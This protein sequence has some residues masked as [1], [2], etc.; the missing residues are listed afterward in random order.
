MKKNF[1]DLNTKKDLAEFLDITI[2]QL[3]YNAYN[4]VKKYNKFHVPKKNG[5]KREI[6]APIPSLKT[7]QKKLSKELSK[8]YIPKKHVHSYTEKKGI[9]TNA[10]IHINQRFVFNIDLENFFPA[11]NFGRVS[12]VF[13][14]P[15]F[16]FND[17]VA[18]LL[19]QLCCH[20]NSLPQGSP[21]S[22]I[23]SN[24]ICRSLD[25]DLKSLAKN[26]KC[27]YS[28]YADDITFSTNLRKF[29]KSLCKIINDEIQIGE[30]LVEIIYKNGFNINPNKSSLR[31]PYEHQYVTGLTV[32]KKVNV[33][34][35]FLKQV[36]A[37][38]HA[39]EIYGLSKAAQEHFDKY[40]VRHKNKKDDSLFIKII[41]GKLL[42][43]ADIRGKNDPVF[44]KLLAKFK[45]LAP[46]DPLKNYLSYQGD[47]ILVYSEGNTD[48]MHLKHALE[49]FNV[50]DNY[51][52][53]NSAIKIYEY[54]ESLTIGDKKLME[55]LRGYLLSDNTRPII[56]V[57]DSDNPQTLGEF[58]PTRNRKYLNFDNR[59]FTFY[60]PQPFHRKTDK[61][62]IEHYY[63]NHDL[64]IKDEYGRRIFL[65][66][67]FND[68]SGEHVEMEN[69]RCDFGQKKLRMN[70]GIIDSKVYDLEERSLALSKKDFARN[71]LSKHDNFKKVNIDSFRLIFDRIQEIIKD[72]ESINN[73]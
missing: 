22:P 42:F 54:D 72:I 17:E 47:K 31:R 20:E 60:L 4:E 49:S 70:D 41:K 24:L 37:M 56:G 26:N 29:P 69:V 5:R 57:F 39:W 34:R 10:K 15:P 43:I 27:F 64:C 50:I 67:E 1:T 51:L 9:R 18:Y 40:S 33:N 28:R 46:K 36:R 6:Y 59:V 63:K 25:N 19:A 35:K 38:L 68:Q 13:K 21:C 71:I 61:N 7:I 73:D 8:L 3:D 55:I 30:K 23:I 58:N 16:N 2:K 14:A 52:Q 65:S 45:V 44:K 62:C 12:G 53:V 48:W 66:N 32:N 11:I